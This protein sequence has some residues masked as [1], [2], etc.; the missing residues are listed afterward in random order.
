[1]IE[2]NY[3][4]EY[5][6]EDQKFGRKALLCLAQRMRQNHKKARKTAGTIYSGRITEIRISLKIPLGDISFFRGIAVL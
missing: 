2:K 6:D 5:I 1:M 4:Y 3:N